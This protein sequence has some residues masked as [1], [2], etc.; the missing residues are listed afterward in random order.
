MRTGVLI[1]N[2]EPGSY[3]R[4]ILSRYTEI[5]LNA[6]V[7]NQLQSAIYIRLRG[8][9]P[10]AIPFFWYEM[11]GKSRSWY[12]GQVDQFHNSCWVANQS[13]PTGASQ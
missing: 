2:G 7:L 13:S 6:R 11:T 5:C 12:I 1:H 9:S 4:K 10:E 3:G 8:T